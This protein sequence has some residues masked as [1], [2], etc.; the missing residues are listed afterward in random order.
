MKVVNA[1]MKAL[2][3]VPAVV[4]EANKGAEILRRSF[5]QLGVLVASLDQLWNLFGSGH[6]RDGKWK[7]LGRRRARLNVGSAIAVADSIPEMRSKGASV[8]G[9]PKHSVTSLRAGSQQSAQVRDR[10]A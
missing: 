6:G 8:T 4:D 1:T 9:R 10:T 5:Q 7:G 3:L 2:D